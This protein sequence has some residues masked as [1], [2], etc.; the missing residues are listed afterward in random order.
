MRLDVDFEQALCQGD[1]HPECWDEER[2]EQGEDSKEAKY[3][4]NVCFQCP[5]RPGCLDFAIRTN[6]R[7]GIWGGQDHIE[8]R[9]GVSI[10][11]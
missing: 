5:I 10:A 7:F 11:A 9:T 4:K 2:S 3:A 6:Q 8:R 1:D